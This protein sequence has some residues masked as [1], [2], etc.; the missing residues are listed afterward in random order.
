MVSS[1]LVATHHADR[2]NGGLLHL[3]EGFAVDAVVALQVLNLALHY[4][5]GE[6]I[7]LGQ[8]RI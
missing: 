1:G 2:L 5:L 8:K 6:R 3:L 4:E 7:Y